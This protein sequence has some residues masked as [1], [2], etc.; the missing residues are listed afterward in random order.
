MF[1]SVFFFLT[2]VLWAVCKPCRAQ[3]QR[4][5]RRLFDSLG[6]PGGNDVIKHERDRIVL[7]S[8][9]AGQHKHHMLRRISVDL[10]CKECPAFRVSPP[11][12]VC[13]SRGK[14]SADVVLKIAPV[15]DAL[16]LLP[17]NNL[18][19]FRAPFCSSMDL[20]QPP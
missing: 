4:V 17:P 2:L 20:R 15:F 13:L 8:A 14:G 12:A 9:E 7:L 19:R 16:A 18:T 10:L 5:I 1:F 3:S 11:M 6:A